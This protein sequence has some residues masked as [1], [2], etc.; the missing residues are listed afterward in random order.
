MPNNKRSRSKKF[1]K[2]LFIKGL[3]FSGMLKRRSHV[4]I[5]YYHSIDETNSLLSISE[6]DFYWQMSYLKDEGF[7]AVSLRSLFEEYIKKNRD[8]D[9]I[10]VLNLDDGFQNNFLK[11]LP[12]LL[13]FGHSAT[14]FLTTDYIGGTATWIKRDLAKVI[15]NF[16]DAGLLEPA[17]ISKLN[18][19]FGR[20]RSMY[21]FLAGLSDEE[22]R[23][24][25]Y[26]LSLMADL[27]LMS[28]E[29]VKEMSSFGVDFG[30]HSCS[31][32]HFSKLELGE[33]REEVFG[34]KVAIESKIGRKVQF[35]CYPY[36]GV[37]SR[38]RKVLQEAEFCGACTSVS[39]VFDP[40][41]GPYSM[42]RFYCGGFACSASDIKLYL[43]GLC[44]TYFSVRQ[45][46]KYVENSLSRRFKKNSNGM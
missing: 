15:T 3:Y 11:A 2:S 13:K 40:G 46:K 21:P 38:T 7:K 39:G 17:N 34:S 1:F 12:I 45:A 6:S 22:L 37:D 26:R 20:L 18:I 27:P 9:R 36:G 24:E 19:N 41:S 8:V 14:I 42:S 23:E 16:S 4:P 32:P 44:N 5:L 10:V 35:F 30:A 28:W 25:V 29:E 33:I 43:S 31:H